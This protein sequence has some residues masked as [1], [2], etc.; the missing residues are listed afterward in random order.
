[1]LK[2]LFTVLLH[3]LALRRSWLG[4]AEGDAAAHRL[5]EDVLSDD[6][7]VLR[8]LAKQSATLFV[9]GL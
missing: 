7:R 2:M 8:S 6:E 3:E 9:Q 4:A 5:Y 1:M